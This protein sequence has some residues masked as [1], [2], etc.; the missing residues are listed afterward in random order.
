MVDKARL[1]EILNDGGEVAYD[2]DSAY[3][4][5]TA[6]TTR[7]V[8]FDA[9][10]RQP[11][12][13]GADAARA[14]F[15]NEIL[16]DPSLEAED[17]G[18]DRY[19]RRLVEY[20]TDRGPAADEMLL[21][22]GAQ[23]FLATATGRDMELTEGAVSRRTMPGARTAYDEAF[24]NDPSQG[25][26]T[27][28]RRNLPL[29]PERE[30]TTSRAFDRGMANLRASLFGATGFLGK[31]L[32]SETL[33][34]MGTDGAE[35]AMLDAAMNPATVGGIED[36]DN[37]ADV[38][39]FVYEKVVENVP[40]LATM[41]AGGGGGALIG[42]GLAARA[43]GRSAAQGLTKEQLAAVG[44]KFVANGA[45]LGTLGATY[46]IHLGEGAL[47]MQDA[48]ADDSNLP[49]LTAAMNSA[50][51]LAPMETL[52]RYTFKG[53]SA[54]MA[55]DLV[56]RNITKPQIQDALK[57]AVKGVA[58]GTVSEGPTEALQEMVLMTARAAEDPTYD[59]S[60]A[61][62][63][64][65]NAFAAG[66]SVGGVLGGAGGAARGVRELQTF[67]D[68]LREQMEAT[69]A[70]LRRTFALEDEDEPAE[71]Q[72]DS[73]Q[74]GGSSGGTGDLTT[75]SGN[76]PVSDRDNAGGVRADS[77]SSNTVNG[78]E[79]GPGSFEPPVPDAPEVA[80][81]QADRTRQGLKRGLLL[82]DG[83]DDVDT[84]GLS[85]VRVPQ[86]ESTFYGSTSDVNQLEQ[87]LSLRDMA[88]ETGDIRAID[89]LDDDINR[90][91]GQSTYD[92]RPEATAIDPATATDV[93]EL[94]DQDGVP[95][96]QVA[97]NDDTRAAVVED[98]TAQAQPGDQV[99]ESTADEALQR[100]QRPA[101]SLRKP[102]ADRPSPVVDVIAPSDR[103]T[104][105]DQKARTSG[106]RFSRPIPVRPGPWQRR[107]R[108]PLAPGER[109]RR[110]EQD[111]RTTTNSIAAVD[112][113]RLEG[114][115]LR[116][117]ENEE[118]IREAR[119]ARGDR[120]SEREQPDRA[121]PSEA[122]LD[123][124]IDTLGP[125][126][127]EAAF[128]K[129]L[130]ELGPYLDALRSAFRRVRDTDSDARTE[131]EQEA[132]DAILT[133]L[134]PT[135]DPETI[136]S[137]IPE[138]LEV[139]DERYAQLKRRFDARIANI[140]E[141]NDEEDI[142]AAPPQAPNTDEQVAEVVEE[143]TTG[144]APDA[145]EA[146]EGDV[147]DSGNALN[148]ALD[149]DLPF[150][151]ITIRPNSKD[152][153]TDAEKAVSPDN[154]RKGAR[155]VFL[156]MDIIRQRIASVMGVD[157]PT[158]E[159]P[160]WQE[161]KPGN[162]VVMELPLTQDSI[163]RLARDMNVPVPDNVFR[164]EMTV[165][166][167]GIDVDGSLPPPQMRGDVSMGE[168][169]N[170]V[171]GAFNGVIG[172][173]Y[174]EMPIDYDQLGEF[175]VQYSSGNKA[176][177]KSFRINVPSII[178]IGKANLTSGAGATSSATTKQSFLAGLTSLA[179]MGMKLPNT[180][181]YSRKVTPS[182][183]TLGDFLRSPKARG[184]EFTAMRP[185]QRD[186]AAF[187][188]NA[189]NADI[190]VAIETLL[191]SQ[192]MLQD[193]ISK[194]KNNDKREKATK[195]L[196]RVKQHNRSL[197]KE[198]Q[199]ELNNRANDPELSARDQEY[200]ASG[201]EQ[202]EVGG[203]MDEE[204]AMPDMSLTQDRQQD[205]P[206]RPDERSTIAA[207]TRE[208][209]RKRAAADRLAADSAKATSGA[210]VEVIKNANVQDPRVAAEATAVTNILTEMGV[211]LLR[212]VQMYDDAAVNALEDDSMYNRFN[213]R[214]TARV[215]IQDGTAHIYV[216]DSLKAGTRSKQILHEV[217]HVVLRHFLNEA[218]SKVKESLEAI[219]GVPMNHEL[220]E[221]MFAE[222]F[223][224]W[225][226]TNQVEVE[227]RTGS[228][229]PVNASRRRLA[230]TVQTFFKQLLRNIRR[231]W[232]NGSK[233]LKADVRFNEFIE[234]LMNRRRRSTGEEQFRPKERVAAAVARELE[235]AGF[236]ST[237]SLFAYPTQ[238]ANSLNYT[239]IPE[240][241]R[242][243]GIKRAKTML[244]DD[245]VLPSAWRNVRQVWD[246]HLRALADVLDFM[247]QHHE[248]KSPDAFEHREHSVR[249]FL[250]KV[251]R[252]AGKQEK[253]SFNT[254][255]DEVQ[256]RTGKYLKRLSEIH[257]EHGS[258]WRPYHVLPCWDTPP[259]S[260]ELTRAWEQLQD[261]AVEPGQY[262]PLA[263][264]LAS[265]LEDI[266]VEASE[267]QQQEI[268]KRKNF[269]P[270][271]YS[272]AKLMN[273]KG[274]DRLVEIVQEWAQTE[275]AQQY[276]QD[277]FGQ[278]L[279]E[280]EATKYADA[281]F[282]LWTS[283]DAS[284]MPDPDG[285][286]VFTSPGFSSKKERKLDWQLSDRLKEFREDNPIEVM[287]SYITQAFK[288]AA[289][290]G[291]MGAHKHR[292]DTVRSAV[293]KARQ[294]AK[295]EV[296]AR[297]RQALA[298]GE[299]MSKEDEG[300]LLQS[301]YNAAF[302][303]ALN[304]ERQ[305]FARDNGG[306]DPLDPSAQLQL[307]MHRD[308]I[309][310]HLTRPEYDRVMQ[311]IV[312][313]IL[314]TYKQDMHPGWRNASAFIVVYQIV[315]LLSMGVFSQFV[316]IGTVAARVPADK[317]WTALKDAWSLMTDS[318]ERKQVAQFALDLGV[319]QRDMMEHYMNDAQSIM[320]ATTNLRNFNNWFFRANQM[321]QM[322]N[323]TRVFG[324]KVGD[325]M[326]RAWAKE[327]RE[328]YLSEIGLSLEEARRWAAKPQSEAF[329][330][331]DDNA[332]V[333]G[334]LNQFVDEGI[335]RPTPLTKSTLLN[336]PRLKVFTMLKS[337]MYAFTQSILFR[338]YR[339]SRNRFKTEE[340]MRKFYAAAPFIMLG[341]WALPLAALGLELRWLL[342][343]E[344]KSGRPEG[345]DY[346]W[347]L[348]ERAGL[349]GLAQFLFDIHETEQHGKFGLVAPAGPFVGQGY[350][351]ITGGWDGVP[352]NLKRA[353][354]AYPLVWSGVD[355]LRGE[356]E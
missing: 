156:M 126:P 202:D 266:R 318:M 138:A 125:E 96:N 66:A 141:V 306:I 262:S 230:E 311:D 233:Q 127:K 68:R 228:G 57:T 192:G 294:S 32:G 260:Q 36:I 176:A 119:E 235:D 309:D 21:G 145:D 324:L 265:M 277:R 90:L 59:W 227:K 338:A 132:F 293:A 275:H 197:I 346:S 269:T 172:Q 165:L 43:A 288:R 137:E 331:N 284:G 61:G 282:N 347:R 113:T 147:A 231:L 79:G 251:H 123:L 55:K 45:R 257:D 54:D 74:S 81:R 287:N 106:G 302:E 19:G 247:A 328:D 179:E 273:G 317:Q 182:G 193:S 48:G 101:L 222:K 253:R 327:G 129:T 16:N 124:A 103:I 46:P 109:E 221:E 58:L 185:W 272:P 163:E 29:I 56:R 351:L 355:T 65:A 211:R 136:L 14:Y 117:P 152:L 98:L 291:L 243:R 263:R 82:R 325:S 144:A 195:R 170:L 30:G 171:R 128:P 224:N 140:F 229:E 183:Y 205:A 307:D 201:L 342:A 206:R 234:V 158:M 180:F 178:A 164:L 115:D 91:V 313:Q 283:G 75:A 226:Q 322:T 203:A 334:A 268:R 143:P 194:I 2:G 267:L 88:E 274:R 149:E 39:T 332:L 261:P 271:M 299:P 1:L 84:S 87:L 9:P 83:V 8:G 64:I 297:K 135:N 3:D 236:P 245:A 215:V 341:A 298:D 71:T 148:L 204:S 340:G 290:Q 336:D 191:E 315:R 114:R 198:F 12:Q 303:G 134:S 279:T 225:M 118:R 50:L 102:P 93:V 212:A 278:Q 316:D 116:A 218:P 173:M 41:A 264:E 319:I 220:F 238:D 22:G 186:K 329:K 44:K 335:V 77:G 292:K 28:D 289:W 356:D 23:P 51:D 252:Q 181:D 276:W 237:M 133:L 256:F 105:S 320:A 343:G 151:R 80:N 326:V 189:S 47:E 62:S 333:L 67:K 310:G 248:K 254:Y 242:E 53:M 175:N 25:R 187:L 42:R 157:V 199:T 312:P 35:N 285:N 196:Q 188:Q 209:L 27:F 350:D 89:E 300:A 280:A 223:V 108:E 94:V 100:R 154:I 246:K 301:F 217:G 150:D 153:G 167:D 295:S 11:R 249:R 169:A 216:P 214:P 131:K 349:P 107:K 352:R 17:V 97:V 270:I 200:R 258:Q 38:G 190:F 78:G 63:R 174:L 259:V 210:P 184:R 37:L 40:N 162:T 155:Q 296:E 321:H 4:G 241:L 239:P 86:L 305:K 122:D 99:V 159:M 70:D 139:S 34:R 330:Y 112:E 323:A 92:V 33:E 73:I 18:T 286:V 250:N 304:N 345:L 26:V 7:A 177:P 10:E 110:L 52:L 85:S 120:T 208:A 166:E 130:A 337:F 348:V 207:G 60:D 353:V 219:I 146:A 15:Q 160:P 354:P 142:D 339:Q 6:G 104:Y 240:N 95:I 168:I 314:G 161:F 255:H 76:D 69:N 232:R 244:E 20:S 344:P 13:V 308:L 24:L 5:D 72:T 31:K 213:G 49:F 281:L 111:R 121:A